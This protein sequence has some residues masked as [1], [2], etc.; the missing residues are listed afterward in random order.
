MNSVTYHRIGNEIAKVAITSHSAVIDWQEILDYI[1]IEPD[2]I[3]ETPWDF[4]DGYNHCLLPVDGPD[5]GSY[6]A[7]RRNGQWVAVEMD[8]D[9]DL[10]N[11]YRERGASKGVAYQLTQRSMRR[12]IKQIMDWH[13]NGWEWW[14]VSGKKYNCCCA[15]VGGIDDYDYAETVHKIDIAH[16]LADQLEELGYEIKDKP[17]SVVDNMP[18]KNDR[19]EHNLNLFNM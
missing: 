18:A 2:D 11:W 9:T 5:E 7:F 17:D 3:H 19:L 6:K 14:V 1:K 10:Y 8:Y 13:K 15:S 12:R 16:E 4:C